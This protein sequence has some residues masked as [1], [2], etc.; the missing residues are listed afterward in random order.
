[1]KQTVD[2]GPYSPAV[3]YD[4]KRKARSDRDEYAK[5][6]LYAV[7]KLTKEKTLS[8]KAYA[9][10]CEMIAKMKPGENRLPSEDDL[11]RLMGISRADCAGSIEISD[12]QWCHDYDPREGYLCTPICFFSA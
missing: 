7:K 1:M 12:H 3:R 11:A 9:V 2:Q 10:L 5:E 6:S 4:R 8:E